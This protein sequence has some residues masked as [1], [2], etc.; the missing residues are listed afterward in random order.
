M[1]VFDWVERLL[2]LREQARLRNA[3]LRERLE[4]LLPAL[5]ARAELDAWLVIARE[6]NEDPVLLSLVPA[7]AMSARRRTILLFLRAADG[8]V[9]RLSLD[10]YGFGDFYTPAWQP[11]Q[12]TQHAALARILREH[13]PQRI[14]I[15][16]SLD[17]AFGDGL[18]H[19]EHAL[20]LDALGPDW[21]SRLVSAEA[22]AIGWLEAR[23]PA[24]LYAYDG[25]A[26][27]AHKLIATL[28]STRVIHPGVTTT[29]DLRWWLRQAMQRL[30]VQPWFQPDVDIQARG[31]RYDAAEKRTLIQP[32]DLLWCDV[33]FHYLGLATDHQQHAYVL[34]PGEVDAPAGMRRALSL[35]NRLQE[36]HL[37]Q[38][39]PGLTGN[40]VLHAALE[41]AR[42]EGLQAQIYS[43][44]LGYHGHA[45][46]PTIG[47]WD[48]QDGVPGRGDYRLYDHTCYS[49]E[50]NIR[51][52]LP[53]W[54]GQELRI[55]L[56]EDAALVDGRMHWLD[57]RQTQLHLIG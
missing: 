16:T 38:M 13:N 9:E 20:L 52:N 2:P 30:G 51:C 25:I 26:A 31:Q 41:Q 40:E 54:G 37:A 32:G 34:R 27:M 55:A 14:G 50:L 6:Y 23:I 24:E 28:F 5:M 15:N 47:L 3:W 21:I 45:A 8:S 18:S 4:T 1:S 39:R 11:G 53:E 43:H 7:P 56:E 36:I 12:E 22:L 19:T 44:P 49:I 57:G 17:F 46:G 35:G 10:R 42:R 33:G 29:E 48:Q